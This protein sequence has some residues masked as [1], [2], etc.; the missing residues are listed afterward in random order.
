[1]PYGNSNQAVIDDDTT[2][3]PNEGMVGGG[4]AGGGADEEGEGN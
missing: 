3:V 1:M 2:F 4:D